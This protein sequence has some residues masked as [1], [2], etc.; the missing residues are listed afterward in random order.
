MLSGEKLE[1]WVSCMI[2]SFSPVHSFSLLDW[3]VFRVREALAAAD[4]LTTLT[5]LPGISFLRAMQGS[6]ADRCCLD[7]G[8]TSRLCLEEEG[9][10]GSL[11][12]NERTNERTQQSTS[13][14]VLFMAKTWYRTTSRFVSR[15]L[16][17]ICT[18]LSGSV[19]LQA[20]TV[21]AYYVCVYA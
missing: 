15:S 12:A 11:P 14:D 4:E 9:A 20:I 1:L 2:V 17:S 16:S 18:S 5:N 6:R 7:R 19:P 10:A 21:Q 3:K 13:T 8:R